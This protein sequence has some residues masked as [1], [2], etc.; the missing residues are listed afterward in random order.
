MYKG[1]ASA[2]KDAHKAL[3][4]RATVGE[5]EPISCW[6]HGVCDNICSKNRSIDGISI[7]IN[8]RGTDRG[9]KN[10]I[11]EDQKYWYSSTY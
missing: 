9:Y 6:S 10:V 1:T 4:H 11:T 3:L 7:T 5:S 2:G 8:Q